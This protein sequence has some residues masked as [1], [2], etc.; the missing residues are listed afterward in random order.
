MLPIAL[1]VVIP[2]VGVSHGAVRS[3]VMDRPLGVTPCY[4]R[5]LYQPN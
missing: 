5:H 2:V 1:G 3:V 4:P